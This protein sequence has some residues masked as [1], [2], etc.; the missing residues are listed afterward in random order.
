MTNVTCPVCL[1][2]SEENAWDAATA[3]KYDEFAP[4]NDPMRDGCLY[5]CPCCSK[6]SYG[7]QLVIKSLVMA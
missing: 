6:R 5:V 3:A 4:L 2:T 1:K 7:Y